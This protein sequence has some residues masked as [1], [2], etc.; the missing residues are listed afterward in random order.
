MSDVE[1]HYVTK[2]QYISILKANPYIDKIHSFKKNIND[3]IPQLKAEKYDYIIDLHKNLR[4]LQLKLNVSGIKKTFRKLNFQKWL[5][6]RMNINL[7]PK[8][9]IVDRYLETVKFLGI[10]NDGKGLEYF[11][12]EDEEMDKAELP[13]IHRD[14]YIAIVI[15]SIHQTKQLPAEKLIAICKQLNKAVVLLGG[16]EDKEK[17]DIIKEAIGE[18]IY[19]S[20]GKLTINRSA[21]LVKNAGKILTNDTGLM[22]IA[23]AFNKDIVSVWG[24][25]VPEF[26]MIPYLP[27]ADKNKSVI[28][29]VKGL[30]C[31]PCTKLGFEKWSQRSF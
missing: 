29:E 5:L 11:I 13:I 9:H 27:D 10:V 12:P 7:L 8:V 4:S 16:H 1:V 23:A 22:H 28:F 25:T 17:G 21:S 18:K 3:I 15:G 20:C 6:V 30:S 24:N 26:G 19:N 31:R 14:G 2:Q